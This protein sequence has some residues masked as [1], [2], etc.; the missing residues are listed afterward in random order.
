MLGVAD[1]VLLAMLL[2]S[3]GIGL[4]RGFVVEV[5]SLTVWIGDGSNFPGQQHFRR[6]F[7]RYLESAQHRKRCPDRERLRGTDRS[8]PA[9]RADQLSISQG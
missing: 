6:A 4:W 3:M 9:C 2:V 1:Y 5:L 8:L 7:D